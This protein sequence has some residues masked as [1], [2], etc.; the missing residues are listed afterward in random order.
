[1]R[2]FLTSGR[3][4]YA[5]LLFVVGAGSLAIMG[6]Q[7]APAPTKPPAPPPGLTIEPTTKV[8]DPEV[9]GG[10]SDPQTFTVTNDGTEKTGPLEVGF[11]EGGNNDQF[12]IGT[13]DCDLA[14]LDPAGQCTVVVTFEPTATGPL[15]SNLV[16]EENPGDSVTAAL[17][18]NG[19]PIP[20]P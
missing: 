15:A 6:A 16:V 7:C 2:K 8:F 3:R 9:I 14:E 19:L 5:L 10:Q 18:G 20:P 4:R 12:V 11:G 1:M 13:E 17:S